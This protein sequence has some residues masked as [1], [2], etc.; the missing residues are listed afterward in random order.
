MELKRVVSSA[1][2]ISL[3]TRTTSRDAHTAS[4]KSLLGGER[5][6]AEDILMKTARGKKFDANTQIFGPITQTPAFF[7]K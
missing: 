4:G 7:V 5:M 1:Y 2:I 3:L 6:T